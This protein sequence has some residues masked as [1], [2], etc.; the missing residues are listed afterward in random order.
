M[1]DQITTFFGESQ[2]TPACLSLDNGSV[3]MFSAHSPNKLTVNEDAYAIIPVDAATLILAVADGAGG[4]PQADV[5]SRLAIQGLFRE[6]RNGS[7]L[8]PRVAIINGFEAGQHLIMEQAP[9]AATTLV[10]VEI[11]NR[12]VRTYHAG[13]SGACVIGGRGK[14]KM[15]TVFHSPTGYAVEA[16][17]LTEI[18]AMHD[19]ARNIVSNT[20]GALDMS[21]QIGTAIE[22][23][24][25]DTVVVASDGLFDNL[26]R[27]EKIGRAHV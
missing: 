7:D 9:R 17:L 4:H 16:G 5:A 24:P 1:S 8:P 18:Q 21:L 27:D 10:V 19:A 6:I 2:I 22:L 25:H 11:T 23:A 12:T 26:L 14:C 3:A 13:D 15:Q 20:L